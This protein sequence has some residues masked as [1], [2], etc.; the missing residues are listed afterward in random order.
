MNESEAHELREIAARRPLSAGEHAQLE[1]WLQSRPETRPD[2]ESEL[3]LTQLLTG[4][5]DVPI[6]ADFSAR[7]RRAVERPLGHRPS[8]RRGSPRFAWLD[9]VR[10]AGWGWQTAAAV[11]LLGLVLGTQRYFRAQARANLID[12]VATLAAYSSLPSVD[13][14]RDFE[15]VQVLPS[16]SLALDAEL[17]EVLQ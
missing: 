13:A 9:W 8:H 4:L 5:P 6:A 2:W 12:S 1:R 16:S 11:L 10:H 3:R 7:V 14:L 15:S 17:L